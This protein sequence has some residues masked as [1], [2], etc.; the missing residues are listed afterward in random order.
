MSFKYNQIN[1]INKIFSM[2]SEA[3]NILYTL[4]KRFNFKLKPVQ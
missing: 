4:G 2:D 3:M 1:F